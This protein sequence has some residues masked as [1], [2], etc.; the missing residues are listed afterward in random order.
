MI[1]LIEYQRSAGRLLRRDT[2][3]DDARA[4][5]E[6]ARLTLELAHRDDSDYEVVLLD[7][8]SETALRETHGRYFKDIAALAAAA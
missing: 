6:H 5:A 8:E 3:S 1:Y 7:A 2:F 4:A